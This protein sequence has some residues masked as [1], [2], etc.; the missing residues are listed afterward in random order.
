MQTPEVDLTPT[1]TTTLGQSVH[2]G[3]RTRQ[4][5]RPLGSSVQFAEAC[6]G[7]L[8]RQEIRGR[9]V[10]EAQPVE[11]LLPFGCRQL[12]VHDHVMLHLELRPP[13]HHHLPV[14]ESLVDSV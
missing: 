2:R 7:F 11:V 9:R 14:D 5:H 1:E 12:I 10:G 3:D 4:H 8:N 13:T 6:P